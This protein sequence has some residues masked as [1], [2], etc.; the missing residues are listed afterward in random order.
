MTPPSS[1]C[2]EGNLCFMCC[3]FWVVHTNAPLDTAIYTVTSILTLGTII[4]HVP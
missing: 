3:N 1:L 2:L 4:F